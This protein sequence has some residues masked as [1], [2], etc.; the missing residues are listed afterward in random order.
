ALPT[1][2]HPNT[3][4]VADDISFVEHLGNS[5]RPDAADSRPNPPQPCNRRTCRLRRAIVLPARRVLTSG[6]I[7]E[8]AFEEMQQSDSWTAGQP[9]CYA[10][11]E[12]PEPLSG[13]ARRTIR[14]RTHPLQ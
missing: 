13:T 10:E 6:L 2:G 3:T 14:V 1:G 8:T 11:A 9:L 5:G 7:Q 4:V 12:E